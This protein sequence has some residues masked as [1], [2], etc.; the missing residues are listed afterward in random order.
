MINLPQLPLAMQEDLRPHVAYCPN[1]HEPVDR[2]AR[3]LPESLGEIFPLDRK[4]L[5]CSLDCLTEWIGDRADRIA[6]DGA[7]REVDA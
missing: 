5:W 4:S 1:C 6:R 7:A 3:T 2:I